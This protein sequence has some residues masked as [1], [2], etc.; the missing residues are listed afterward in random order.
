MHH[1]FKFGGE[2]YEITIAKMA[3]PGYLAITLLAYVMM[4]GC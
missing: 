4:V 2:K 1:E 3:K